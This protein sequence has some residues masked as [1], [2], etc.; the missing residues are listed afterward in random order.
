M[1]TIGFVE[2]SYRV[3]EGEGEVTLEVAVL[4]GSIP[5]GQNVDVTFSTMDDTATGVL[6]LEF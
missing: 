6:H 4:G 2:T 5:A 1:V 3:V